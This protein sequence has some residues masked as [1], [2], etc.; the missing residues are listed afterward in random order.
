MLFPVERMTE[1]ERGVSGDVGLMIIGGLRSC[2]QWGRRNATNPKRSW[3]LSEILSVLDFL[4]IK[5]VELSPL[6]SCRL[7]GHC[8]RWSG[9]RHVENR[10]AMI[11]C[12]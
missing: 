12:D 6:W 2:R 7:C 10:R 1:S 8:R 11:L 4:R 3:T 5:K 9:M